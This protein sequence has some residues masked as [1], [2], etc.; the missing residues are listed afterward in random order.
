MCCWWFRQYS[1]LHFYFVFWI[2]FYFLTIS[3]GN[4]YSQ[5]MVDDLSYNKTQV[6]YQRATLVKEIC[7]KHNLTQE[8]ISK[9]TLEQNVL[10]NL[11]HKVD[12][13]RNF[14]NFKAQ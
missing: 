14:I 4:L 10:L 7:E 11:E 5:L 6:F 1:T 8:K 2:T 9:N 12:M 13:C 3:L